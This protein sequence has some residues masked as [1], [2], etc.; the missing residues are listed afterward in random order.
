MRNGRSGVA[1]GFQMRDQ[2]VTVQQIVEVDGVKG[3]EVH[4]AKTLVVCWE[5]E[6]HPVGVS[7]GDTGPS[8]LERRALAV[9]NDMISHHGV[10]LPPACE[11]P[12]GLQ[13][14]LLEAW[15]KKLVSKR[16]LEG[17]NVTAQFTRLR[18]TLMDRKEIDVGEDHVWVPL[19]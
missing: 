10:P 7:G 5:D 1:I 2:E 3:M 6:M 4:T 18:N 15:G 9:L 17:K 12:A 11:A 13:G 14:V 16:I 19:P 8:D